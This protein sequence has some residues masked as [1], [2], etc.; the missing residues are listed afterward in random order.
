M[1]L[2]SWLRGIS[3]VH[4]VHAMNAEQRQTDR[5]NG[6]EPRTDESLTRTVFFYSVCLYKVQQ[7][8]RLLL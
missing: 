8:A 4:P 7:E 1:V 5:A 3:W 2:A 6:F